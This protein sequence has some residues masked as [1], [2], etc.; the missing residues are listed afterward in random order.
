MS[1]LSARRA[2]GLS[3]AAVAKELG[4]TDA[5][6]CMWETGKTLPRASLIP[7]IATLYKCTIDEL[8]CESDAVST[9]VPDG[10]R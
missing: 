5:A 4:V 6:V 7:K 9:D 8:F 2:A 3:Q 1:F 10:S